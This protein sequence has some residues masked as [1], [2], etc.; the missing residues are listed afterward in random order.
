ML[1]EFLRKK[2]KKEL[3]D[4][5]MEDKQLLLNGTRDTIKE[6]WNMD[7]DYSQENFI[8]LCL[9][10]SNNLLKKKVLFK[11]GINS[12]LI[13]IRLLFNEVLTTR[14]CCSFIISHNHPTGNMKPSKQDMELTRKIKESSELLNLKLLD[15]IIISRTKFYSFLEEGVI[16]I[17]LE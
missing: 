9:D 14:G 2:T 11:G 17:E 5:I 15:H 4:M 1:Y 6:L 13:D 7:I 8:L 12:S 3:I 10:S 16:N